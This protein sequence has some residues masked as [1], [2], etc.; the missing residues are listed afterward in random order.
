MLLLLL[1]ND[2]CAA[3]DGR[4]CTPFLERKPS[5]SRHQLQIVQSVFVI[6]GT[7]PEIRVHELVQSLQRN[8]RVHLWL[9]YLGSDDLTTRVADRCFG[10]S[11]RHRMI[12]MI[13]CP[14]HTEPRCRDLVPATWI[15]DPIA[16]TGRRP[17]AQRFENIGASSLPQQPSAL[18]KMLLSVQQA[19]RVYGGSN[20]LYSLPLHQ[21]YCSQSGLS[22]YMTPPP[23]LHD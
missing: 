15:P 18:Y 12:V 13:C 14:C 22:F 8:A 6:L 5:G 2:P 19:W 9:D 7:L 16:T 20:T 21:H 4:L 3:R 10:R 17:P 11:H 23:G 1:L